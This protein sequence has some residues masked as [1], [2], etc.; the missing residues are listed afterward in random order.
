MLKANI[1]LRHNR[2]KEGYCKCF[3]DLVELDPSAKN[4][5]LLG[6]AYLKILNPEGAVDAFEM[7]YAKE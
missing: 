7:A 2:D 3:T 1:L 4:Y 6:D 5:I